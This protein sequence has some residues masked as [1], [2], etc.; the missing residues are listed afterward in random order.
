MTMNLL[1]E[2]DA[3]FEAHDLDRA[4]VLYR[5]AAKAAEK[6][7]D[8]SSMTEARAQLAR[9]L[10][11]QGKMEKGRTWLERAAATADEGQPLGWARYQGVVGRFEWHENRLEAASGTFARLFEYCKAHDLAERAVDAANMMTIVAPPEAQIEWAHKAIAEAEG[12]GLTRSLAMIWNNLGWTLEG[13]GRHEESLE[14]LLRAREY[15]HQVSGELAKLIADWS[16]G[17]AHRMAGHLDQAQD[18]LRRTFEWAQR[19][20]EVDP[21]NDVKEWLAQ[22]HWE[23]GELAAA[24]SQRD[25]ARDHLRKAR[26]L[27]VETKVED[28]GPDQ[29]AKLDARLAE[30]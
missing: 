30:L 13:L 23:L 10:L 1:R 20:L 24:R 5:D 29:L 8:H 18:W 16:V 6:A 21:T 19:R 14:A 17:H 9:C 12:R 27:L 2:A 3:A 22:C 26:H 4:F 11:K 25:A 15:H 7:K 28:W